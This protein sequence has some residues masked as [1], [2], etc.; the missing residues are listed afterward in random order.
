MQFS[1]IL[2]TISRV[3]EVDHMLTSLQK[4]SYQNFEV[5]VVDQNLDNR[6]DLILA[7][8]QLQMNIHHIKI[9]KPGL[10]RA[11]NIGLTHVNGNIVAFPDDDCWYGDNYLLEKI[12][13]KFRVK[14]NWDG[15]S[16]KVIDSQGVNVGLRWPSHPIQLDKNNVFNLAMSVSFFVRKRLVDD[17][18][19]YDEKLGVGANTVYG[20]GEET[21]YLLRSLAA[22]KSIHYEPGLCVN[23]PQVGQAYNRVA[24]YKAFSYGVGLGYVVAKYKYPMLYKCNLIVRP[25]GGALLNL[26]KPK[27]AGFYLGS[28]FGRIYGMLLYLIKA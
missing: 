23:H 9:E 5:I 17:V 18:G 6:L 7:K 11:R 28:A 3:S 2:A 25:L 12:K 4:Q 10:S 26:L 8:H 27:K 13:E 22:N 24:I 15:L 19:A 21:D 20:S 1:L 14:L 16:V